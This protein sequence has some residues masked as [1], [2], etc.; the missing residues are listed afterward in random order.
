MK[1]S[2]LITLLLLTCLI[3]LSQSNSDEKR[4]KKANYHFER[5]EY[6]LAIK[7]YESAN[8]LDILSEYKLA[9]SYQHTL[10][11]KDA[12][13][14]YEKI[15]HFNWEHTDDVLINYGLMAKS[16]GQYNNAGKAFQKFIFRNPQNI[17][18]RNLYLSC[19]SKALNDLNQN[20]Y[21]ILVEALSFNSPQKDFSPLIFN[22]GIAF[23]SSR[24]LSKRDKI[25]HRD[26]F[27]FINLVQVQHDNLGGYGEV[28]ILDKDILSEFHEGP[29]YF[30]KSSS[31]IYVTNNVSKS[32]TINGTEFDTYHLEIRTAKYKDG[33]FKELSDFEL[34][35]DDFSVGHPSLTKDGNTIYFISDMSDGKGGTDL[36][37]SH[38]NLS[39]GWDPP[40]NLGDKINTS[41]NELFPFI[42]NDST[43]FFSSDRHIGLGGLDIYKANIRNN[44]VVSVEN[45]GH[46]FNSPKDDFGLAIDHDQEEFKGYFSSN[47]NG[48]KGADDIYRFREIP[49]NVTILV[50]DSLTQDPLYN[51]RVILSECNQQP[52]QSG[53]TDINGL[54]STSVDLDKFCYV[55]AL[56]MGYRPKTIN[57]VYMDRNLGGLF[58]LVE[59]VPSSDFQLEGHVIDVI[60][61]DKITSA[62][63]KLQDSQYRH[64]NGTQSNNDGYFHFDLGDK[65]P[66]NIMSLKASAVGYMTNEVVVDASSINSDGV[67][68][69]DIYLKKLMKNDLLKIENIYYPFDKAY[70]TIEAKT[71]LNDL[72]RIMVNN[73]TMIVELGSHCDIRGSDDYNIDLSRRRAESVI[74]YLGSLGIQ[75]NRLIYEFYGE[76]VNVVDCIKCTENQHQLNRRTEFKIL[77]F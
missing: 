76:K 14:V 17:D 74:A 69:K 60:T 21:N 24:P 15:L 57:T 28:E 16:L 12:V 26:G 18:V 33:K 43:L 19:Q 56:Q 68:R 20:K 53:N 62:H 47:R 58:I 4:K 59:L 30:D 39:G 75:Q 46:P 71:I 64:L 42:L 32:E 36:Y 27:S 52:L 44:R 8:K 25:H 29:S 40:Y 10:Q 73:P 63:V 3:G 55:Q 13:R 9:Y 48:G 50:V 41:G 5:S 35:T 2:I 54:Y 77:D 34:N 65:V 49:D 1:H 37:V 6:I 22:N 70:L 66:D 61:G 23:C 72:H 51:A 67:I 45:M 38:R 7:E 31:V 11:Y